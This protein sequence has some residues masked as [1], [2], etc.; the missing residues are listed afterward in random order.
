LWQGSC[1]RRSKRGSIQILR[2]S[3]FSKIA[4]HDY[5]NGRLSNEDRV[6]AGLSYYI[7]MR[8]IGIVPDLYRLPSAT[9]QEFLEILN[10]AAKA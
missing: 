8:N 9:A 3:R 5:L 10:E 6:T 4:L 7:N 2:E 1:G